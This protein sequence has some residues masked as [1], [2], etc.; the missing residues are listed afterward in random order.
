L[1][2]SLGEYGLIWKS[3]DK[4]TRFIYGI[5]QNTEGNYNAFDWSNIANNVNIASEYDWCDFD[6]VA[7]FVG[8]T[9]DDFLAW[10]LTLAIQTLIAYYGFEE[11][12]GMSYNAFQIEFD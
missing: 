9:K 5:H 2:T 10:E 6:A 11:I 1:K 4:D 8:T 12:F 7:A 3:D